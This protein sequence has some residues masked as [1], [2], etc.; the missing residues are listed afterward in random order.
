[1]R[2][3]PSPDARQSYITCNHPIQLRKNTTSWSSA[4]AKA[5]NVSPG[6]SPNKESGSRSSSENSSEAP[7]LTSPGLPVQVERHPRARRWHPTSAVER[8]SG[9]MAESFQGRAW[10]RVR[11]RKRDMVDGL[12]QDP[13]RANF[14][15]SGA[16]ADLGHGPL[17]W[18][19]DAGSDFGRRR[20]PMGPGND[21]RH[22]HRD[23]GHRRSGVRLAGSSR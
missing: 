21:R 5:E 7:A 23:S 3:H 8:S 17:R 1:M 22:R 15:A 11:Q 13:A 20:G 10:W 19:Q 12:I 2:H 6:L 14:K 4:V 16:E 18:P 9:L